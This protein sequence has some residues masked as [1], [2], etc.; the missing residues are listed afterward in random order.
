MRRFSGFLQVLAVLSLGPVLAACG[1]SSS[2]PVTGEARP[3][4][5]RFAWRPRDP[6]IF[7]PRSRSSG[8]WNPIRLCPRLQDRRRGQFPRRRGGNV[9]EKGDILAELDPRDVDAQLRQAQE[10]ADKAARELARIRQLHTKGFASDAALQ[11]AEAQAKATRASA[12]AARS[13][14]GY[15]SIVAPSDGVVLKRHIE[16]NGVVAAGAPVLTLSDMTKSFVLSVGLADR[17]ALRVAPGDPAEVSFDAFPG[18]AFAASVSEIGADADPRTRHL[19][20][21]AAHRRRRR[22]AEERPRRPRLHQATTQVAANVAVPVDALLEGHGNEAFVFVVDPQTGIARRT[23]IFRRP[24]V[25]RSRRRGRRARGGPA[26]RDRRRGLSQRRR[27]GGDRH[28]QRS[29]A[30][31]MNVAA[32]AVRNWQFTLVMTLLF[33]AL[34]Y[35]AFQSIPRAGV[36]FDAPFFTVITQAPGMEA[37]EVEKLITDP[38]EDA[39]NE[40]D[41]VHE[42]RSTT[43]SGVAVVNVQFEWGLP[44]MDRKYDEII[45][46]MN[47]LRP[48]YSS[49]VRSVVVRKGQPG[50]TNI[51]QFS[52]IGDVAY[53]E[54]TDRARDLKDLI[55]GVAGVRQVEVWGAPQPEVRV[56]LDLGRMSRLGVTINQ[57]SNAI[58][59]ENAE[60]PGGAV[61]AGGVRF[62]LKTTGSYNS[63]DEIADTVVAAEGAALVRVRDI[64]EVS[65]A[66]DEATYTARHDGA[67][68][69]FVTANMRD[70]QSI[71]EVRD[72]I[73]AKAEAFRATLPADLGL[74]IAFDR[75]GERRQ[76]ARPARQGLPDRH[77]ARHAD[78]AA[79]RLSRGAG[80][81]V[82]DPALARPRHMAAR[83]CRLHAEPALDLGLRDLARP[84]GRQ[85]HR[86]GR[87]HRAPSAHG[88][89]A[90]RRGDRGHAADIAR[91]ARL[92]GDADAGL[93]AAS[94]PARGRRRLCSTRARCPWRCC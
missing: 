28:R 7:S 63:I 43:T 54:L 56:A 70:G 18:Q 6:P 14:R 83:P 25:G 51:V 82:L 62:N 8:G 48:E 10:A 85:F 79:A 74:E 4:L 59:G 90:G 9:I 91:R 41:D 58:Q 24:D 92:H 53:R 32:F 40:L 65:W 16:A 34:G 3:R 46:E 67:K 49:A 30:R 61:Q 33:A 20:G 35:G 80:R 75:V 42:I 57:V 27:K 73:V 78:P 89:E 72:A 23:R 5:P 64:A 81:D 88:Q 93:P 76:A 13:N 66:E 68:A 94:L 50:Y 11:D 19:P 71:F 31:A 2:A 38:I 55:E 44:N 52:L 12:Q 84:A 45:R 39:F 15:A 22:H 1:G 86:G 21:R 47:R 26:G 29:G 37:V 36:P 69:V 17:D 77:R 60:I 87:E